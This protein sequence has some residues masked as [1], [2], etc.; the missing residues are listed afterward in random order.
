MYF[1]LHGCVMLDINSIKKDLSISKEKK[2]EMYNK[3]REEILNRYK[4]MDEIYENNKK[5]YEKNNNNK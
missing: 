2:E 1:Y 3:T 4:K 5:L